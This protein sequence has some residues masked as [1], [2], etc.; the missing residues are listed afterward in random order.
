MNKHNRFVDISG[1]DEFGHAKANIIFRHNLTYA[2]GK[3]TLV[4]EHVIYQKPLVSVMRHTT[5][6]DL[7]L[8]FESNEDVDLSMAWRLLTEYSDPANSVNWTAEEVESGEYT[9][10]YGDIQPIYYHT[11]DV[12]LVPVGHEEEYLLAGQNP[13]MYT[14]RPSEPKDMIP[15]VLQMV[16]NNEWFTVQELERPDDTASSQEDNPEG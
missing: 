12:I 10:V 16:F 15:N 8:V 6:T 3:T 5:A 2:D 11:L 4:Q 9:D 7:L 1:P 13:V 14:L